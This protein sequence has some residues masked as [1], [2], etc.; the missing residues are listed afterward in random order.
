MKLQAAK[1]IA[2]LIKKPTADMIVPSVMD[3]SVVKAVARAV[4]KKNTTR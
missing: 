3:T 1:N 4:K 2:A